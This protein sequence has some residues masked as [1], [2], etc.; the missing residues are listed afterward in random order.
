MPKGWKRRGRETWWLHTPA[1][2]PGWT[3][4]LREAQAAE[5]QYERRFR[6]ERYTRVAFPITYPELRAEQIRDGDKERI[7]YEK[8]REREWEQTQ[9]L[10][11]AG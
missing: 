9:T 5:A 2:V 1:T 11:R 10:R 3:P 6:L 4:E 8:A 7:A